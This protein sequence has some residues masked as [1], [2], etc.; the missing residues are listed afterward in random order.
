MTRDITHIEG[1]VAASFTAM[2]PDCSINLDAIEKQADFMSGNGVKGV[3]ICGTTGEGMSLTVQERKDIARRWIEVA[4]KNLKVIVHVG[5]TCVKD[6]KTLSAHAQKIGAWAIGAIAPCFF[7]PNTTEEL[8]L[9]CEQVAASAPDL[10]F[11]FYHMPSITQV[12]FPMIEFL[13]QAKDKIPNLAGIKY[14][15]EDLKDFQLCLHYDNGRFNMLFGRDEIL[16]SSL[17]LGARGAVGSTY[18]FAAPLYNRILEAFEKGDLTTARKLQKQSVDLIQ[19]MN[20]YQG[21]FNAVGKSIMKILGIDCGPVRS[22]LV[23][24]TQVQ[25]E[26]LKAKLENN[27]YF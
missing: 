24:I 19:L 27:Q 2:N 22:P 26:H 11:Y 25:Y 5:H 23:N 17:V 18:N 20:Q 14:T 16:L 10:P 7:R 13:E 21:S 9:F 4:P 8:I 12:N 1:F 15:H 6:C 3:F